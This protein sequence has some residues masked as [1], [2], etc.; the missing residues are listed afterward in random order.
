VDRFDIVVL[1]IVTILLFLC[2]FGFL[3]FMRYMQY[4]ETIELARQG[5]HSKE[6]ERRNSRRNYRTF[7][8]ITIAIGVALTLAL[9]PVV[10]DAGLASGP[11][12]LVGLIPMTI[13]VALMYL[14]RLERDDP[15]LIER[16]D[17]EDEKSAVPPRKK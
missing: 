14:E 11:I 7:G 13:G 5:V 4:R 16:G 12:L 15:L 9:L 2:I 8:L 10:I 6:Q 17:E 1:A 3:A